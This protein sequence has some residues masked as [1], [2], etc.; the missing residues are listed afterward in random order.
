MLNS[1]SLRKAVR[2]AKV[3]LEIGSV[4]L[5]V[6]I[7]ALLAVDL[8]PAL[9]GLAERQGSRRIERPIHIGA[10]SVRLFSGTF[11]VGDLVIE[12]LTPTDRP[13]LR[14]KRIEVSMLWPALLHGEVLLD[15]IEMTDWQMV[16]ETFPNG[17]HSFP[18]FTSTSSGPRRFTT[19]SQYIH[20]GRGQ[21][22][23]EDHVTPW[24]T[25]ARNLDVTVGK[26]VGYRGQA[27]FSGGTVTIQDYVPMWADMKAVFRIDGS[28]IHF[29]RIDLRTDGAE[30]TLTGDVDTARWPEQLYQV[31][32]RVHFP[33]MR[34]LFFARETYSLFGDG[35]F[36]GT[37]HLFKGGRELKGTFAS[38]VA[39][40]NAYRFPALRG[41]LIWLPDRFAV[42]EAASR[43]YGGTTRFTYSMAPFGQP[44]PAKAV[45]DAQYQ[46]VDLAEFTDF[47]ELEG[48]R[49]TGRATGRNRLE[50]PLGHFA[51]HRGDGRIVAESPRADA[52][53]AVSGGSAPQAEQ[54]RSS[55]GH[56]PINGELVYRFDPEWVD[57]ESGRVS[58]AATT[59]TFQGRTAYG[60]RSRMPF[61]VS[62]ADWQESDRLLA[63]IMTAFGAPTGVVPVGGSGEFTGLM[64]DSFRRPRIEG[65]FAGEHV[66]AWDVDWGIGRADVVIEDAY[67]DVTGGRMAKDGAD[68]L[69][70]GR[71]S[72]GFPRRDRGEELNARVRIGG[73][74]LTDLRHAFVLDEYPVTGTAS[75]DYHLY[76]P[77]HGPFGFGRLTIERG[78]AYNEPFETASGSLRFEGAG[79]RID[80]IDLRKSSGAV[81][82]AAYIGWNGTYS[83]DADGVRIPMESIAAVRYP[84]AP[85]TG[86]MNFTATG[87]GTFAVP[88]YELRAQ[89]RDLFIADEGVG[90]VTGRLEVRGTVMTMDVE[91]ASPRLAVSGAGRIALTPPSDAEL[92]FRFTN[93]SLDPYA[94]AFEPRLSP[95][96]TAVG[97]GTLRIAGELSDPEH[98][99]V[100]AIFDQV[101]LRLFDYPLHNAAPIRVLYDQ[102][103]LRIDQM[104][105][106]G[107]DTQLDVAGSV[108]LRARRVAATATGSANLSILQG[109]YRDIRS[110]GQAELTAEVNG[111]LDAP[112]FLG[113]ASITNGRLRH[114]SL[115]HSLDDINGRV[116]FDARSIRVDGVTAKVGGGEVRFGGR[117]GLDGYVPADL[118]L[119]AIG[120]DINLR[121]PEGVRS[122]IDADLA[123]TGRLPAPTLT[124]TVTVRS[125][126]WTSRFTPGTG[127]LDFTGGT[128]PVSV[129]ASRA[130]LFPVRL[131]LRVV[132]PGTLRIE[133]NVARIAAS[134]DLTLRGTY[135]R[136]VVFGR[137]ELLRGEALFE[138]RRYI[139]TRG[140]LD[141]TNPVRIE[142]FFDI[143]AET[144]VRVPGQTYRVMMRATGTMQR[145]N[146]EF[147]SDPPLPEVDVV[148]LLFGGA[149]TSQ[150]AELRALQRPNEAQQQLLQSTA[151]RLLVSPISE[152]VGRVVEQT[153]GLDTFQI[154]PLVVD[155]YQQS[156]RFNPSARLTIGKRISDRVYLTYSRS[157]SYSNRDQ[158]VMV[159]YDQ[160]DRLSWVLTRNEDETYA[161]DVRVR[162]AF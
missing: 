78:V 139:V 61:H 104:R 46:N 36:T 20:A 19:T 32:S 146:P 31:R 23:F 9:R 77:Y 69:V 43:F 135:D 126:V 25:V 161:L 22:T 114:F 12:G 85:F 138:G 147:T 72:L 136:P 130:D 157:L 145:L 149:V 119:T 89:I 148:S 133:N 82:G 154:T 155:P 48:I 86:L 35:D 110:S 28:Q 6:S 151:A 37:F 143:E 153:F 103:M 53:L 102:S 106:L 52:G 75:G 15:S 67:V 116:L 74:P 98:L 1:A 50:W 121:Y 71:F 115:P 7:V 2:F 59:V 125:M 26:V 42:T 11:V 123:L 58:T 159:E 44:E 63:G 88:H 13:F 113:S 30:S 97:S 81:T 92:M 39:G 101:Q 79:V 93:T 118:A 105:F 10:L 73:W 122:L 129:G 76:G 16:I 55:P 91:A 96:T 40:V 108:D 24:S 60:E 160:S 131:D 120:H 134:A 152:G 18:R 3:C 84:R 142:P 4:A 158:I 83:F 41:S 90:Q 45:F 80:G 68:I 112:A 156:S 34:E 100:E 132:A 54:S 56:V 49:L 109:F 107:E 29:D 117:V 162:H 94:R 5:A 8:G 87:S 144:H 51:Q 21:F 33:R 66:R 127:L 14:A 111:P 57:V 137:A 150:D 65:T 99:L 128:T 141:F 64:L 47:L 62:S 70:E 38:D 140:T 17:R 95:F 27:S 124:G